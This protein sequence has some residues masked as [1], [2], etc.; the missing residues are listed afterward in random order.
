[1]EKCNE[2][3][4]KALELAEELLKLGAKGDI[5]RNDDS[6]GVL[7]GVIRDSGYRIKELAAKEKAKHQ[8]K[9]KWDAE[10]VVGA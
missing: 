5:E 7:F 3:I 1:M 9:G 10:A 8:E 4:L 2:N 6:C